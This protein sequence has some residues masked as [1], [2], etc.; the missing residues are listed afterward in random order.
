MIPS[1][2]PCVPDAAVLPPLPGAF[3]RS[4]PV[5]IATAATLVALCTAWILATLV[6][7]DPWKPDEA[8]SFGLVLDF[9]ERGDW[10]VPMLAG[11]PFLE[12]PPL[13]FITASAFAR[14]F[15]GILPLHDAARLATGFYLVVALA[16]LA[17]T[18]RRLHAGRHGWAA[19]LILLGSLGF[20]VRAHQLITDVALLAGLSIGIYG[21]AW[22]R[23]RELRGGVALGAGTA[24][25]FL[26]KGLLGPGMLALTAVALLAHRRWRVRAYY[27]ALLLAAVAGLPAVVVWAASLYLRS[28][29]LFATWLV[30]NNFG[31]FLGLTDI[32]PHQ[33]RF[34]YAYTLLWYAFPA[35]PLAAWSVWEAW[36]ER[37][38]AGDDAIVLPLVLF[39]VMIGVLGAA[40][41][42]RELYLMPVLLPLALLA[43]A[44]IDRLPP[45]LGSALARLGIGGFGLVGLAL[46]IGWVALVTG[47]PAPLARALLE[48]QPG[49]VPKFEGFAFGAAV[50]ATIAWSWL[51]LRPVGGAERG[52][53]RWTAG[54][55]LCLCLVGTLWLPYIDA[56]KSY[57]E[58]MGSLLAAVRSGDCVASRA[59]GEPQRALLDY[60]GSLKTVREERVPEVL[61]NALLVQGWRASGAPARGSDWTPVW[62]GARAGD[63]KEL[64]R[65]YVRRHPRREAPGSVR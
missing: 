26:A 48:R 36:R 65:L 15:G 53:V 23:S 6:G 63:D 43:T 32:G 11:E 7:H 8:Y 1:Y 19:V 5:R 60:Y 17:M 16:F 2:S 20:A 49:F 12:K 58:M 57:R 33:P 51:A 56:G 52:V 24:I 45:R 18:A 13:F 22:A 50:L 40:S 47:T 54:V 31:R 42:A 34:F 21:L 55:T 25:A 28:P 29:D 27:R 44:G 59:L 30:T 41:D 4:V 10:V 62:E 64:Y 9:L 37:A 46:W 38:G 3:R 61:C 39:V 35:L 14:A